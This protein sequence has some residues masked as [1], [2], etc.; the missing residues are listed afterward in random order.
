METFNIKNHA[1]NDSAQHGNMDIQLYHFYHLWVGGTR[2]RETV[3]DH[4]NIVRR[5]GLLDH[6][7]GLYVGIVGPQNIREEAKKYL[8]ELDLKHIIVVEA[9]T[10]YEQVTQNLLYNFSLTHDG[11]VLYAHNKGS[12]HDHLFNHAW[13]ISMSYHNIVKW[14][15]AIEHLSNVDAVGCHW[16]TPQEFP[17]LVKSPFFGGTFWWTHLSHIKALGPPGNDSR[18][19]AESWIGLLPDMKVY[20]LCPGWPAGNLFTTMW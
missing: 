16:L 17:T 14:K 19:D 8:N 1:L 4:F 10:G 2:W 15:D 7:K 12:F 5:Y 11:Y 6:L 3:T 9:D 13:R 20:D 18:Y